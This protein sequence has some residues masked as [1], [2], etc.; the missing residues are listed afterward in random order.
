MRAA[1]MA[2]AQS[3]ETGL[4]NADLRAMSLEPNSMPNVRLTAFSAM[5]HVT[6]RRISSS[7][8]ASARSVNADFQVSTEMT[9]TSQFV[10][11]TTNNPFVSSVATPRNISSLNDSHSDTTRTSRPSPSTTAT[12]PLM[13][14][15]QFFAL[16]SRRLWSPGSSMRRSEYKFSKKTKVGLAPA[17]MVHCPPSW[18]SF[19]MATFWK[20]GS[21]SGYL[22]TAA[23][24][25]SRETSNMKASVVALTVCWRL[26]TAPS[27]ESSPNVA[28][29]K[30]SRARLPPDSH[31]AW[32][33]RST[34]MLPWSDSFCGPSNTMVC[35]GK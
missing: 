35:P 30:R 9:C 29:V 3:S 13:T 22:S 31:V 10:F 24:K 33:P 12:S 14:T 4:K 1:L 19:S 7:A 34:Y 11:G 6:L 17:S 5:V 15:M 32:P 27:R 8:S 25:D 21:S 16:S 23:R 2:T 18:P 26:L 28:P 20:R